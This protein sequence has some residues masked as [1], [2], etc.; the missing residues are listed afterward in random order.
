VDSNHG[1]E[2]L[3]RIIAT[4]GGLSDEFCDEGM[5]DQLIVE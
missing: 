4:A 1:L 5:H 3:N 2:R